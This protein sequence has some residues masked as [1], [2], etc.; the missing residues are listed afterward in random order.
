MKK[1]CLYCEQIKD[2]KEFN[3]EHIFPASLGGNLCDDL[4]EIN[5]VCKRCNSISGLFIDGGFIKSW[6]PQNYKSNNYKEY[7]DWD[8][9]SAL[10]LTYMGTLQNIDLDEDEVCELW[11][12]PCGDTIYHIHQKDDEKFDSYAGG[13]PIFRR[14][15]P[16]YAFLFIATSHE[17]WTKIVLLS[18]RKHFIDASR[19]PGNIEISD[20][21]QHELF[22]DDIPDEI[23]SIHDQLL[24]L[25]GAQHETRFVH[26]L[27]IEKRFMCKLGLG[28]GYKYLGEPF[29]SSAYSSHL[30]DGM[31]YIGKKD[32]P[33]VPLL[34]S[35]SIFETKA[36]ISDS[37]AFEGG[38]SIMLFGEGEYLYL[39]IVFYGKITLTL[40]ICDERTLWLKSP[41][42]FEE[43]IIY[44]ILPQINMWA[45]PVTLME[46]LSHKQGYKRITPLV[47]M[48]DKRIDPKNLPSWI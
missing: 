32:A 46:Y 42:D 36:P 3:I 25:R 15:N 30:R 27:D 37:I 23:K 6:L 45:G 40:V 29:L 24:E 11:L 20:R 16:G 19:Y 31:R 2:E 47:E 41:Y 5:Q 26:K 13:D 44:F 48:E 28:F 33:H 38:H 39:T 14:K 1:K 9:G 34:G 22:F 12:G 18:F 7:L 4:F 35:G 10:P 21:E 43:G 8:N 17:N